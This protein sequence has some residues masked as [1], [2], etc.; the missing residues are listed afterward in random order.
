M[1]NGG[2]VIKVFTILK[3][4]DGRG[5]GFVQILMGEGENVIQIY[6]LQGLHPTKI[7]PW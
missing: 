2:N 5:Y 6:T 4:F 3:I 7:L 1:W